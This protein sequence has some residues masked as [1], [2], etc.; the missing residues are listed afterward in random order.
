MRVHPT[1]LFHFS[2]PLTG[3]EQGEGEHFSLLMG[4]LGGKLLNFLSV[5]QKFF[6]YYFEQEVCLSLRD[7]LSKLL[8]NLKED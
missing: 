6:L 7:K 4:D 8:T 1:N 2:S 5:E 3:E